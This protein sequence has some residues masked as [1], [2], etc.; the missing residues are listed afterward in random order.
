M[1]GA[2]LGLMAFWLAVWL[3]RPRAPARGNEAAELVYARLCGAHGRLFVAAVL[4]SCAFA[5]F[6]LFALVHAADADLAR[7][8]DPCGDAWGGASRGEH[9]YCWTLQGD[10]TWRWEER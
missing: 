1:S 3:A 5:L 2:A 8:R 10:G 7:L 4:A 6:A 9:I